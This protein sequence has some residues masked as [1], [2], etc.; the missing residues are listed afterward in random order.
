[1][2]KKIIKK[3]PMLRQITCFVLF[4]MKVNF[5]IKTDG[6]YPAL[7]FLFESYSRYIQRKE[8]LYLQTI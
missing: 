6:L 4:L 8:N 2:I 1:M 3:N 5:S 7:T